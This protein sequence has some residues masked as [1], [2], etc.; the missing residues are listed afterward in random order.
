MHFKQNTATKEANTAS[1]SKKLVKCYNFK[2][3]HRVLSSGDY[4]PDV[5]KS[6]VDRGCTLIADNGVIKV[7]TG[8]AGYEYVCLIE[9]AETDYLICF[10]TS[11]AHIH[12][13]RN[14]SMVAHIIEKLLPAS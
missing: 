6:L 9:K 3:V 11:H 4:E 1:T 2:D 8:L 13:M 5:Q 14:F 12:W 10:E 7:F